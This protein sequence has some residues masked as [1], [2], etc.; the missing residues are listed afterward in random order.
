MA[1]DMSRGLGKLQSELL[2]RCQSFWDDFGK[3]QGTTERE[4]ISERWRGGHHMAIRCSDG[5]ADSILC[6]VSHGHEFKLEPP[7]I[8]LRLVKKRMAKSR[9]ERVE[10]T[11]YTPRFS[12][13]FSRAAYGLVERK[14]LERRDW[15]CHPLRFVTLPE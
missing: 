10:Y 14:L 12:A 5:Y 8:D 11:Q 2:A 6:A 1:H 13:A 4:L 15:Q 3:L 7:V 9:P